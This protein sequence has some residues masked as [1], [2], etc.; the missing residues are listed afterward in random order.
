MPWVRFTKQFDFIV[1]YNC[2]LSYKADCNY[3]VKQICA[4]QAVKEQK[5]ILIERPKDRNADND[6]AQNSHWRW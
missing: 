5:A 4:E 2:V 3:L 6:Y 1:R